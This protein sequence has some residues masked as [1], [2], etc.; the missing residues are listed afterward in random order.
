MNSLSKR[1]PNFW[2]FFDVISQNGFHDH[3]THIVSLLFN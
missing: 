3:Y 2:Q 1:L